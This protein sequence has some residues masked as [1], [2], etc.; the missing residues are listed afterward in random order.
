MFIEWFLEFLAVL[1]VIILTLICGVTFSTGMI[2]SGTTS[3]DI[4]Y[5]YETVIPFKKLGCWAGERVK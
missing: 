3:C 5:R 2:N 4:K 1:F